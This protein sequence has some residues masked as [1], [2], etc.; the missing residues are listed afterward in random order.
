MGNN[1]IW[2]YYMGISRHM[3]TDGNRTSFVRWYL[4]TDTYEEENKID[5]ATWDDT[6]KFLAERKYNML[7]IDIG[8]GVLF[9]THPEISA[10]DAWSKDFLKQ[11]INEARALGL[12]VIPKLNFSTAHDTWMK[13]YRRMIS[14]PVYYQVCADL[15]AEMCELFDYPRL[16]HLGLDEENEKNQ[17]GHEMVI[18][19]GEQLFWHD[20]YFLFNECEKHGARPWVWSDYYWSN[21]DLFAKHMPKSV[22][23]SNWYYGTFMNYDKSREEFRAIQTYAELERLGYDQVPT[24]SSYKSKNNAFQTLMHSQKYISQEHLA[25]FMSTMWHPIHEENYYFVKYDVDQLYRARVK[26]YPKTLEEK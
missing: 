21:P 12:E 13:Q 10:P 16:F 18:I 19:R 5:V 14:T 7:I 4:P 26:V 8:D 2:A 9:D 25:G 23:Q 15:I 20:A 1:M 3:W 17:K 11:K 24:I 22:L 6:V